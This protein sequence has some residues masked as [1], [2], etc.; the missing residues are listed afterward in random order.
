MWRQAYYCGD[1]AVRGDEM[2]ESQSTCVS[3]KNTQESCTYGD[4]GTIRGTACHTRFDLAEFHDMLDDKQYHTLQERMSSF[5]HCAVG[6][7]LGLGHLDDDEASR[8]VIRYDREL[9]D[10]GQ[11]L[12]RLADRL[13]SGAYDDAAA[14]T[15]ERMWALFHLVETH[16]VDHGRLVRITREVLG[17]V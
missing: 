12:H 4:A 9:L 15:E 3:V 8:V 6:T 13:M 16:R 5:Q 1:T 17:H 7:K 14:E 2:T 11:E 10:M